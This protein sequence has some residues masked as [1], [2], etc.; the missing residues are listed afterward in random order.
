[1][2]PVLVDTNVVLRFL[3]A[4]DAR[5]S[6]RAKALF[7]Q[8]EAGKIRLRLTHVGV[9]EL[10]WVLTSFFKFDRANVGTTLRGLL[11]HNGVE[12]D[13]LDTVLGALERFSRINADFIDCYVA[14]LAARTANPVASYDRDFR[15]FSDITCLSPEEILSGA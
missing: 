9:A 4:D 11:L 13:D 12:V 3:L 8:A 1:M 15:K 10:A 7:E 2:K 14:T 6:P 5:Q